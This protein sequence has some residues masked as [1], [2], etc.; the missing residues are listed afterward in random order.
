[1]GTITRAKFQESKNKLF[2]EY[3]THKKWINSAGSALT[4]DIEKLSAAL[5]GPQE[6][7]EEHSI[8][9]MPPTPNSPRVYL[10]D[11][12]RVRKPREIP[13]EK[14]AEVDRPR[15]VQRPR[16]YYE[17]LNRILPMSGR[18]EVLRDFYEGLGQP[19]KKVLQLEPQLPAV[20]DVI[21][22]PYPVQ[23]APPVYAPPV[24]ID[25]NYEERAWERFEGQAHPT[26]IREII[27]NNRHRD[28]FQ[29]NPLLDD[30][31]LRERRIVHGAPPGHPEAEIH[32][33]QPHPL[34]TKEP[35][36]GEPLERIRGVPASLGEYI[37]MK[38]LP[39]ALHIHIKKGVQD[40]ALRLLAQR[41]IEH[42]AD[43]T[44]RI[45]LKRTR[46]GTFSYSQ[47]INSSEMAKLTVQSLYE[48]LL[49]IT[50]GR[51][52]SVTLVVR[53]SLRGGSI[54][55]LWDSHHSLL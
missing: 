45:L 4:K 33:L 29:Y 55:E 10:E 35:E 1:L 22:L 31:E 19:Q 39:S 24:A 8:L 46:K 34:D 37:L 16:G 36:K 42:R 25:P 3:E 40:N 12:V 32:E 30:F 11:D 15:R 2:K 52:K 53:Q 6:E 50:A 17:D 43:N 20:P 48:R 27:T 23:P 54:H 7:Y 13:E 51:K 47:W 14:M 38:I 41:I 26:A 18:V 49:K 21:H 44:T 5:E 28:F 9:D